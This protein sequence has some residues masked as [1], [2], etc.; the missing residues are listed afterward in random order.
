[1]AVGTATAPED[2]CGAASTPRVG[3]AAR[4]AAEEVLAT[5]ALGDV[6]RAP[7]RAH[8]VTRRGG[9][10]RPAAHASKSTPSVGNVGK[11]LRR[12]PRTGHWVNC[13][14]LPREHTGPGG[15]N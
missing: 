11:R 7:A 8:V 2:E 14:V 5:T 6:I 1:M 15:G 10:G 3:G 4:T 9:G 13:V 12:G